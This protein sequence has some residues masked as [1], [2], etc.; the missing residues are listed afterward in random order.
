MSAFAGCSWGVSVR[1]AVSWWPESTSSSGTKRLLFLRSFFLSF[2]HLFS[3]CSV[4]FGGINSFFSDFGPQWSSIVTGSWGKALV[5][6]GAS[7]L[8]LTMSRVFVEEQ[9]QQ[10]VP[11]RE[12]KRDKSVYKRL[13]LREKDVDSTCSGA[14]E[15]SAMDLIVCIIAGTSSAQHCLAGP[16]CKKPRKFI[17]YYRLGKCR[18]VQNISSV[19]NYASELRFSV[20]YMMMKCGICDCSGKG[21]SH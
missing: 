19:I 8:T 4:S 1:E 20:A 2:F 21:L 5:K 12:R 11:A 3:I 16:D 9:W 18:M 15:S 6:S 13:F 17:G 14:S 10:I 7:V